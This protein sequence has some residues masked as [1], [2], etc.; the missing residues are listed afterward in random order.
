MKL[1]KLPF[2]ITLNS[3]FWKDPPKFEIRVNKELV[4]DSALKESGVAETFSF[5]KEV[6][7]DEQTF[8]SLEIILKD[9]DKYQTVV[10]GDKIIKDQLLIIE[11]L[12]IDHISLQNVVY[13][14]KYYPEYN[15]E[16]LEQNSN[17]P[18][19]VKNTTTLGH[20]GRWELLFTSPFY[21]WLLENLY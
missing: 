8:H 3:S 7:S 9:K 17:L 10:E 2:Q 1:E 13:E 11:G 5:S 4:I 21:L 15:P 16:Y 20:N 12:E 19:Y 14:Q 18:T 6:V